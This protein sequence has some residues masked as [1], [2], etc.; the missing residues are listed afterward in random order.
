FRS[1]EEIVTDIDEEIAF[2]LE[3]RTAALVAQGI[4]RGEA[5]RLALA[6]FG[7]VTSLRSSLR[8]SDTAVQRRTR[9][10]VW[11]DDLR[12]DTRFALRTL[13]RTPAFTTVALATLAVG[14]AA[15]V[16]TFTVVNAVM[17]RPLPYPDPEQLVRLSPGQNA[18]IT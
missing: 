16:A 17:L 4:T 6:E 9:V 15:A 3:M 7:D 2:H 11:W 18:N 8:D 14:I 12:Q 10:S 13:R 1:R 5:E